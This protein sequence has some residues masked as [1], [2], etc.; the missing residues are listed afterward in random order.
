MPDG[1][2]YRE[3]M[4]HRQ[5]LDAQAAEIARLTAETDRL[6]DRRLT[7]EQKLLIAVA[8]SA[9]LSKQSLKWVDEPVPEERI[10]IGVI[11][12]GNERETLNYRNDFIEAVRNGGFE[13]IEEVW[14]AGSSHYDRFNG[15]VTVL[16]VRSA[17][18]WVQPALVA[19]LRHASVSIH[20]ADHPGPPPD[21]SSR[22]ITL[23]AFTLFTS[24]AQLVVGQRG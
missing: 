15:N 16:N 7:P 18:N 20:V 1:V 10:K 13:P 17:E 19:A 4:K 9:E 23:V 24:A 5:L 2:L 11:S 21:P 14:Q 8:L 12:I 6:R 22:R 3:N